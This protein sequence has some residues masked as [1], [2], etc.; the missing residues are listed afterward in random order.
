MGNRF[1]NR[2][3]S[4][5]TT[6]SSKNAGGLLLTNP[7]DIRWCCGFTGSNGTLLVLRDRQVFI[8]DGR[9]TTQAKEEVVGAEIIIAERDLVN[10]LARFAIER[11]I[12]QA[13]HVTVEY[14]GLLKKLLPETEFLFETRLLAYERASKEISEIQCIEQALKISESVIASIAEFIEI[15]ISERRLATEIDY[16]QLGAGAEG[17]AFDTI[18]AFGENSAL[19]HARPS[20]RRLQPNEPILIDTG[21]IVDGYASD[22]TRNIFFGKPTAAYTETFDIVERAVQAAL[23]AARS[24]IVASEL[25]HKARKVISDAGHGKH[26]TH[27][28]GHGVGLEVHEWPRISARSR[29]RL[30]DNAVIT[31]EPG[32]YLADEF[33]IR[34]EDLVVLGPDGCL[35]LNG[36]SRELIIVSE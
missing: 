15:G 3:A 21:C 6:I 14:S 19:P 9:Y 4:V 23:N 2:Y 16:R 36:L 20:T 24:S 17:I 33:G 1:E 34:I 22:I 30:P 29:E 5:L 35:R 27:S 18:V 10:E 26:F 11:L 31:I 7:F 13:D 28:L 8:T 32:I 25:D 12:I